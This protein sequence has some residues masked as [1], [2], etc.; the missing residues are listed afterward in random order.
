MSEKKSNPAIE[1]IT[2]QLFVGA[3]MLMLGGV[4][5]NAMHGEKLEQI[6]NDVTVIKTKVELYH[7]NGFASVKDDTSV[8]DSDIVMLS[9]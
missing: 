5:G 9:E 3:F 8:M 7:P 4:L 6:S 2:A 1:G